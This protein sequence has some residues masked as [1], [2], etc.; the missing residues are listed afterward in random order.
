MAV[1][2]AFFTLFCGLAVLSF[3]HPAAAAPPAGATSLT[4]EFKKNNPDGGKYEF[5]RSYISALGHIEAIDRRWKKTSFK[6]SPAGNDVKIMRGYVSNLV[7]DNADLRIAKNFL[8]KYLRSPNHLIQKT[9]DMFIGACIIQIAI[10]EKEKQI[11]DQWYAVK[12]N[13]LDT[14]ANERAF[15][16][17]QRE[18]ALKRKDANTIIVEASILMTKVLKSEHNAD[19]KGHVLALT[20]RQRRQLLA[21]LDDFGKKYLDWGL[22]SGQTHLEAAVAVIRE[23][24]E[25][26]IYTTLK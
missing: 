8:D 10:N 19:D 6:K 1:R 17:A 18:L 2:Q 20:D 11:W 4:S 12:S 15:V 25:D 23:V 16:K 22:K 7:K 13:K 26:S 14:A 9:A 21:Y 3:S 5:A 24:L